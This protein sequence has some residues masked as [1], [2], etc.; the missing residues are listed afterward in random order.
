MTIFCG[1]L[2]AITFTPET[3]SL[4]IFFKTAIWNLIFTSIFY[5]ILSKR[6]SKKRYI[7]KEAD[8]KWIEANFKKKK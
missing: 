8:K 4:M 7:D 3:L 6:F 1:I 2:G 5:P